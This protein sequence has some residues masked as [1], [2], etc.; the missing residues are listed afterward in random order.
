[1]KPVHVLTITAL[2]SVLL[3]SFHLADDVVLRIEPGGSSNYI[4]IVITAVY[5]YAVLMLPNRRSAHAIVLLFSIGGAGVP[6]LHMQ[7]VGMVGGKSRQFH[8]HVL[9]GLDD[10]GAWHDDD[11][12][13]GAGG[14]RALEPE[15]WPAA[16]AIAALDSIL[17]ELD[18]NR[19]V[20]EAPLL[21]H[22]WSSHD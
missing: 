3:G 16:V 21:M 10:H 1:M 6:Y 8:S 15:A 12:F 18:L 17:A 9:L 4:G 13:R 5:L 22:G 2:L 11:R 19:T 20:E 14:E 7:G